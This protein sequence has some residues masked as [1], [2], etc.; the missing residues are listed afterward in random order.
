MHWNPGF[1]IPNRQPCLS[2]SW[3]RDC[4]GVNMHAVY[5]DKGGLEE[6][7]TSLIF[8]MMRLTSLR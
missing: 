3:L 5:Q 6:E 4:S 1:L 8:N 7:I 2:V